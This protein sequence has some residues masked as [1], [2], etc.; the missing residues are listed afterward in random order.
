MRLLSGWGLFMRQGTYYS[1][2]QTGR[3]IFVF[4]GHPT[5]ASDPRPRPP[6]TTTTITVHPIILLAVLYG[7]EFLLLAVLYSVEATNYLP[8]NTLP[9]QGQG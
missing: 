1:W 2:I 6:T 5:P 3:Y 4:T 8:A 9:R 7:K